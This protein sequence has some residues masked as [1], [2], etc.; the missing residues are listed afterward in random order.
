MYSAIVE[1]IG[2]RELAEIESTQYIQR[3]LKLK[4]IL[5]DEADSFPDIIVEGNRDYFFCKC[6]DIERLIKFIVNVRATLINGQSTMFCRGIITSGTYELTTE[7][8]ADSSEDQN[9]FFQTFNETAAELY[10]RLNN[11][12][13]I[14][15]KI[16][17]ALL[18][19]GLI[20]DNRSLIFKNY[21]VQ[22]YKRLL[23][24]EF[25]DIKLEVDTECLKDICK[26]FIKAYRQSSQLARYYIPLFNN[27]TK[28]SSYK[29][30]S[31][32]L[33]KSWRK[34]TVENL[35]SSTFF[36]DFKSIKGIRII[37]IFFI[38]QLFDEQL[39]YENTEGNAL[40][41]KIKINEAGHLIDLVKKNV[42][43]QNYLKEDVFYE[44]PQSLFDSKLKGKLMEKMY[45]GE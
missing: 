35:F 26:E 18:E 2:I 16:D 17:R 43:L 12:K 28:S 45:G 25:D 30:V 15:I 9:F 41:E 29:K 31:G 27:I 42:W 24:R 20:K 8:K 22:H 10:G 4:V 38:K 37:Y 6:I 14:A 23:I 11:L 5:E 36:N 21:L 40:P 3:I 32:E 33:P 44:V 13:G 1:I 39:C 7:G 19:N 34:G